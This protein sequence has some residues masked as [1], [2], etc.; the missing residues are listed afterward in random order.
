[1]THGVEGCTPLHA[2]AIR[3]HD[4]MV[5]LLVRKTAEVNSLTT[6]HMTA[7]HW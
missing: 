5:E 6:A 7:L 1:M 3:G 4:D 2:A